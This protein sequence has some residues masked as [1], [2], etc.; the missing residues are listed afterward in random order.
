MEIWKKLAGEQEQPRSV[1]TK[2]WVLRIANCVSV[3][4]S[5]VP[6]D[7]EKTK[8][9]NQS[10]AS[11]VSQL[12]EGGENVRTSLTNQNGVCALPNK[13]FFP[14]PDDLKL[15]IKAFSYSKNIEVLSLFLKRYPKRAKI[16][17]YICILKMKWKYAPSIFRWKM[18]WIGIELLRFFIIISRYSCKIY[19]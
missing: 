12:V 9:T 6:I 18:S 15:I 7:W 13:T 17:V 11:G 16:N 5:C 3:A 4:N 10:G 14:F 1:V 19:F 2:D 8:G